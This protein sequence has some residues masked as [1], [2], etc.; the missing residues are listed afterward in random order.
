[1]CMSL[2]ENKEYSGPRLERFLGE[3]EHHF[4]RPCGTWG[5]EDKAQGSP[6]KAGAHGAAGA[7]QR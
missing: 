3:I 4:S 5:L 2:Q 6:K 1:M 7:V